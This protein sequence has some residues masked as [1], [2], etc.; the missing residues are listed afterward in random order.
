MR[1]AFCN[2]AVR[3]NVEWRWRHIVCTVCLTEGKVPAAWVQEQ[4]AADQG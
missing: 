1:C 4:L 3:A 2:E